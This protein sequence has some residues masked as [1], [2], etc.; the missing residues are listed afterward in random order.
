LTPLWR[1]AAAAD[2]SGEAAQFADGRWHRAGL[3]VRLVYLAEHPALALVETL[4][5]LDFAAEEWPSTLRLVRVEAAAE[6]A[7]E[8]IAE[9]ALGAEWRERQ[10]ATQAHGLR[11]LEAGRTAL[12]RVPAVPVPAAWNYLL[13]PRHAQA[14]TIAVAWSK[15]LDFDRRLFRLRG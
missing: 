11:W 1:I 7:I 9:S 4:V 3:G 15:R 13:N 10:E 8:S 5:H 6:V 12:L 14:S 2:F